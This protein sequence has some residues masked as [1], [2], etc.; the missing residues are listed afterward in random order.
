MDAT[1]RLV[2]DA[3]WAR[4][5]VAANAVSIVGILFGKADTHKM[6]SG[7]EFC[8]QRNVGAIR[9]GL[10]FPEGARDAAKSRKQQQ[11]RRNT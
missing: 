11:R 5:E 3:S 9:S 1:R 2:F 4:L 10:H 6:G 7:R 8:D